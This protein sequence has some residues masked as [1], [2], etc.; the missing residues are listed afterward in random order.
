MQRS[1]SQSKIPT[2][3]EIAAE[4]NE[5]AKDHP[6]GELQSVRKDLRGLSRL[7]TS[8]IFNGNT[9]FEE[10]AFHVGGRTELQF[11]IGIETITSIKYFRHGIAFSLERSQS[12]PKI[13]PLIPRIARFNEFIRTYSDNL[14]Q[15][16]MWHFDESG[17]RSHDY[18]PTPIPATLVKPEVFIFLGCLRPREEVE[19]ETILE[20]FDRLLPV[21]RFVEGSDSFPVISDSGA[22]FE[23][24]P[25][26]SNKPSST[27][28]SIVERKLN[29]QLRHND[30]QFKLHARLTEKYGKGSVGTEVPTG[31]GTLVDVV[32]RS[33]DRFQYYEIKTGSSARACIREALAQLLEYSYWPCSQEAESLTVVG[34]AKLD[35]DAARYLKLLRSKFKL[36]ISYVQ[37]E[38]ESG[39]LVELN[40][41][42]AEGTVG[43]SHAPST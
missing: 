3:A 15:F 16:R 8:K 40:C 34:E 36:P 38:M 19:P 35:D 6:I 25:G 4:I 28:V 30:L 9:I 7:P 27:T 17:D 12:L 24:S 29:R 13:D 2:I 20:D 1:S 42:A 11:N 33:E 21:Y 14:S 39:R 22:K 31:N 43:E 32:V 10:F 23:F 18:V 41:S 26:C 5:G 37:F